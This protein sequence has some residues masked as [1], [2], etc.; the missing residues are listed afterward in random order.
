MSQLRRLDKLALLLLV[1]L[2]ALS[3]G[4]YLSP[5]S[6]PGNTPTSSDPD[7]P[8]DNGFGGNFT[9]Q[10]SNGDVS[11]SDFRQQVVVLQFGYSSCPDV[12]PTGLAN[13]AA[14][15]DQLSPEQ[16]ARV[17]PLFISV[18]PERDTPQRLGEYAPYFHPKIIGLTGSLEQLGRV[19][20]SYGAFFRKVELNDSALAYAVDHS[21]RLYLLDG[22]GK[23]RALLQHNLPP[24]VLA[25][26]IQDLLQ[27]IKA[28]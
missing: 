18:D 13:M 28:D 21:A 4:L 26:A 16:L 23:L 11:L 7:A 3:A 27:E 12:C 24:T 20:M 25:M 5:Q 2:L 14:A 15:L 6:S 17:Q 10:S 19:A 8:T 1:L 9:L 22:E